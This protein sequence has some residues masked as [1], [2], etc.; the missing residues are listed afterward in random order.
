MD[1]KTAMRLG[2]LEVEEIGNTTIVPGSGGLEKEVDPDL[3]NRVLAMFGKDGLF[4]FSD[5]KEEEVIC[6]ARLLSAHL[7]AMLARDRH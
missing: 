3:A 2:N 6:A 4:P 7:G 1:A 5:W